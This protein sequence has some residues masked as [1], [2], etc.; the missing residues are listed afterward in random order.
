MKQSQAHKEF[1]P[2]SKEFSNPPHAAR[3]LAALKAQCR[4]DELWFENNPHRALRVRPMI[5]AERAE[6]RMQNVPLECEYSVV[7]AKIG[8]FYSKHVVRFAPAAAAQL[9]EMSDD[10]IVAATARSG[11]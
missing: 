9:A 8:N 2:L 3:P 10:E 11:W 1:L 6:F 5:A 4:H 7:I